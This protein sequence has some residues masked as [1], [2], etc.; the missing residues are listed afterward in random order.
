VILPADHGI[1]GI[2]DSKLCTPAE[3]ERLAR[4]I[5]AVAIAVSVVR[6]RPHVIDRTGLHKSN[7]RALRRA[8]VLLDPVPQYA[9]TDGFPVRRPPFPCL[10]VKKGDRVSSSVAAASIV[11]KVVRDRTMVRLHRRFPEYGF[12]EN[13]GYGTSAHREALLRVGPSPEHRRSFRGIASG[14]YPDAPADTDEDW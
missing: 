12:N 2:R 14:Y 6:V 7:L 13:K 1:E 8:L 5:R 11:A 4:E 9:L 3:R 10:G